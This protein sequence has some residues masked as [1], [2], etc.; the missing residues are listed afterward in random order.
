MCSTTALVA[1]V[2]ATTVEKSSA[3][4]GFLTSFQSPAMSMDYC[5]F[6]IACCL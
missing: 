2:I 3:V 6:S 1:M 5:K 4:G